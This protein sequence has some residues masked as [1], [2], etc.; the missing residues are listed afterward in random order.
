M[1]CMTLAGL[2]GTYLF[3]S[4]FLTRRGVF[5]RERPPWEEE[6]EKPSFPLRFAAACGNLL[7]AGAEKGRS[8][9]F[10]RRS[11]EVA[12]SPVPEGEE[13]EKNAARYG[14]GILILWAFCLLGGILTSQDNRTPLAE[15]PRGEEGSGEVSYELVAQLED[16]TEMPV[17]V[18]VGE[19][20]LT[21]E[22][23]R[24]KIE[25]AVAEVEGSL[26]AEGDNQDQVRH[27][28]NFPLSAAEGAVKIFWLTEKPSLVGYGGTVHNRDL[29]EEGELCWVSARFYCGSVMEERT[30]Y[31]CVLPPLYS[32]AEAERM[33]FLR[34]LKKEEENGRNEGSFLLPA[35]Y[36]E[37]ALSFYP[38]E[39]EVPEAI[40]PVL[41]LLLAALF[42]VYLKEQKKE[43]EQRRKK[44]MRRDYPEILMKESVLLGAGLT[45]SGAL[46]RLTASYRREKKK[47]GVR[48]AYEGLLRAE[49]RIRSGVPEG[50]AYLA[51]GRETGL[52]GYLKLA[53]MLDAS[54]RT[55][56]RGMIRMLEEEAR[57][58][59]SEQ[60]NEALRK[61]E[62]AGMSMLLPML[63][64]LLV[65]LVLIMAPAMQSMNLG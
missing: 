48:Y 18:T 4:V 60:K 53:G 31:L 32:G 21:E 10:S 55:G 15:L 59:L 36:R 41:G 52:H 2:L 6:G 17:L 13:R 27:D 37:E 44:Q 65:L 34:F 24:E 50:E 30:W 19:R 54:V 42:S 47:T 49:G 46:S 29:P 23:R 7:L 14:T 16:G 64:L 3:F 33:D 62:E 39:E 28:L 25:A 20:E 9:F 40:Y 43:E 35:S 38:R 26:F 45:P 63:L 51:F 22:E 11:G 57:E 1:F 61:G 5:R 56:S 12:K 58:A 8:R